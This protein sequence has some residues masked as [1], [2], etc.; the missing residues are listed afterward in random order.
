VYQKF[1]ILKSEINWYSPAN[2][3]QSS[4]KA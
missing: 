2:F 4:A 1:A 3:L